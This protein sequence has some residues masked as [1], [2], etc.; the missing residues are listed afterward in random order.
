MAV[1]WVGKCHNCDKWR[2]MH[3]TYKAATE[4]DEQ[5][6]PCKFVLKCS[7]CSNPIQKKC[8]ADGCPHCGGTGM[9]PIPQPPLTHAERAEILI[10]IQ[11][12]E[13]ANYELEQM[14]ILYGKDYR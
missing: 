7:L 6:K 10:E 3:D 11:E 8:C 1:E 9:H 2:L 12:Q 5:G 13:A 4:R 14:T